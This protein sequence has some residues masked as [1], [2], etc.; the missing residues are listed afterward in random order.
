MK[1]NR[2]AAITLGL[3][4]VFILIAGVYLVNYF[5][6]PAVSIACFKQKCF[7]V[8]L[9]T[10]PEQHASGLS[11]RDSLAMDKGM[12][13]VFQNEEVY[14]FWMYGMKFP[15]DIIW[16]ASNGTVVFVENNALPCI[17]N[18]LCAPINPGG[19]NAMYVLEINAGLSDSVGIKI[20]EKVD[21]SFAGG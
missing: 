16:I 5:T 1:I 12:L 6:T 13:F 17:P 8:E 3:S 2:N 11:N 4:L 14:P 9:A 19:Q 15:I 20:G 18:S 10:S 7:E 21:I